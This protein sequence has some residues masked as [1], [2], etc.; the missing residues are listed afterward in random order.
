MAAGE[1]SPATLEKFASRFDS[2]ISGGV[3]GLIGCFSFGFFMLVLYG[4][5]GLIALLEIEFFFFLQLS[6]ASRM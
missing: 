5:G 4:N 6:Y 3:M 2:G 1:P